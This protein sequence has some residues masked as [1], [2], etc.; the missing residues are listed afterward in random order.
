VHVPFCRRKC[1]Y[2]SF[3]SDPDLTLVPAWLAALEVEARLYEGAFGVFDTLYLGGGTPSL[4]A[5]REIARLVEMLRRRFRFEPAGEI[6]LEANPDDL[7]TEKLRLYRNLGVNRLSLGVQSL[8]DEELAFLGRRHT[9]A[10][11]EAALD[12]VLGAGFA[13]VAVDLIYGLPEQSLLIWEKTL[14]RLIALA[15]QHLS[16]YQL[17]VEPATELGGLR[18]A[19]R[20]EAPGE[21]DGLAFFL[22]TSEFLEAHGY[23]HYE[24]SNFARGEAHI[25]RHN[26]KYWQHL[27]YLGLGPAS[28]SFQAGRRWWNHRNLRAYLKDLAGGRAPLAGEETLTAEQ[29]CLET[30]LLGFRTRFGVDLNVL[31]TFPNWQE[32]LKSLKEAGWVE[33]AGGR[34]VTTREGLAVADRLPELFG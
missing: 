20:L 21:E 34:A 18:Q 8:R 3:Y 11:A 33:V 19:G 12:R 22:F 4:L 30:L 17:T 14:E 31:Q 5:A 1:R 23:L 29:L 6:T 9:A 27:P 24:V 26:C 7:T 13:A 10:Q 2:C 25:A 15:P 32:T 16:C 28:H